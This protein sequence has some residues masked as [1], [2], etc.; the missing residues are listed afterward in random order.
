MKRMIV[1]GERIGRAC[2]APRAVPAD[3]ADDAVALAGAQAAAAVT[4]K[5]S[6]LL[7]EW[8][9]PYDGVP[10][11]DQVQPAQF[12]RGLPVRDRRA[13]A[14]DRGDRRQSAAADLRQHHRR[15]GEGRRAAGPGPDMYG[16]HDQQSADSRIPGVRQGMGARSSRRLHDEITLNPQLFQRIKAVYDAREQSGLECPAAAARRAL[17]RSTSSATAPTSTRRRR[18]AG[19]DQPAAGERVLGASPR[20]V[21]GRRRH[22][23]RATEAELKGVPQD[24]KS[25]ALAAAKERRD[26]RPAGTRSSTPA[27][28]SI[29]S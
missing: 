27:R 14:R 25:A 1:G 15:A 10:P 17:L 21:A 29:R 11:W 24:V 20:K 19:R 22:A 7:A 2:A 5:P 8:T 6:I 13:A 9:G 3:V 26:C 4:P 18:A 16:L 12:P 23:H 28:R